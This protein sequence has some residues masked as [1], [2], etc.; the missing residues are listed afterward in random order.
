MDEATAHNGSLPRKIV[1]QDG[2]SSHEE[3]R[4][5]L[6]ETTEET[7]IDIFEEPVPGVTGVTRPDA[8]GE[9]PRG[10]WRPS[11]HRAANRGRRSPH[12]AGRERL[13]RSTATP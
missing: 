7:V 6:A 10:S 13:R 11:S 2:F 1:A 5:P 12:R 9:C 8:V 3:P 4:A